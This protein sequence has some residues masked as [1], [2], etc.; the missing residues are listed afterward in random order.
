MKDV[1]VNYLNLYSTIL[2]YNL[3]G[4]ITKFNYSLRPFE[5]N[6]KI[7]TFWLKVF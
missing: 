3:N 2:F 7:N 6:N 4:T 5:F 1:L